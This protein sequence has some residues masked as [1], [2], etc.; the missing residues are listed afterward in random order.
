LIPILF[1]GEQVRYRYRDLVDVNRTL[2]AFH[3]IHWGIDIDT[4]NY[5]IS[6]GGSETGWLR[7]VGLRGVD[8]ALVW[9]C[10]C[11]EPKGSLVYLCF[12]SKNE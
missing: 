7:P 2:L 1:S 6:D 9:R 5:K 11:G 8:G 10:H 3:K 4:G 12:I